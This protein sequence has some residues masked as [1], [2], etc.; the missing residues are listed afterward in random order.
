MDDL[1]SMVGRAEFWRDAD[2]TLTV[3]SADP[4]IAISPRL[5]AEAD[6]ET[7]PVDDDGLIWLAGDS[8]YRYRPVRFAL[9]RIVVCERVD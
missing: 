6:A 9:G 1:R 5:L 7:L 4:I 2:D 8:R 3:V